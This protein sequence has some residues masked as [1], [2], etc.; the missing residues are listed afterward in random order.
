MPLSSL[1]SSCTTMSLF[2]TLWLPSRP[3]Q[4]LAPPCLSPPS[5]AGAGEYKAAS[6]PALMT[7]FYH[8][9]PVPLLSSTRFP[10]CPGF[11]FLAPLLNIFLCVSP[12]RSRGFSF[13][14][15]SQAIRVVLLLLPLHCPQSL[16]YPTTTPQLKAAP[17]PLESASIVSTPSS[18]PTMCYLVVE[19]Y[20]VCRCLYYKH[21]IDMCAAYGTQGH[22]VQERTVLVGYACE[23]HSAHYDQQQSSSRGYSDSGYGTASHR[24]SHRHSSHRHRR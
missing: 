11:Y 18:S 17:P 16:A 6:L 23:N 21:S 12:A 5:M 14:S 15:T 20:S 22:P 24:S 4:C 2:P 9:W 7:L 10:F 19:R 1:S 8:A 13:C 3:L